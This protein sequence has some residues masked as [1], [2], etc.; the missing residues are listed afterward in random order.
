MPCHNHGYLVNH[1][2]EQC[3]LIKRYFSG[4]YKMTS[5]DASFGSAGNEEKGDAYPDPRGCLMIFGRPMAYESKHQQKLIPREVN[6]ATLG[7]A[8][9]AYLKWSEVTI[10]FNRNDHPDHIPQPR[11]FALVIDPIIGQTRLS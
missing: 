10:T 11:R 6:A 9:P 8:I 1:T 2:L 7:E 3:D 5:M 4:D